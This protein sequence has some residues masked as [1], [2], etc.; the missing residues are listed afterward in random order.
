MVRSDLKCGAETIKLCC[1]AEVD[2]LREDK[3]VKSMTSNYPGIRRKLA[4]VLENELAG[5]E[6]VF[7]GRKKRNEDC[8]NYTITKVVEYKTSEIK[9]CLNGR[10]SWCYSVLFDI[11]S[12]IR[13]ELQQELYNYIEIEFDP[14]NKICTHRLICHFLRQIHSVARQSVAFDSI[15]LPIFGR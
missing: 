14:L 8:P 6:R 3:P 2:A 12:R 7:I 10:E 9:K 15:I 1:R 4:C 13:S 11:L 5:I